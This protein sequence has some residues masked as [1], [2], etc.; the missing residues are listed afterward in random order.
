MN[1]FPSILKRTFIFS[2]FCFCGLIAQ[3]YKLK[4]SQISLT[5]E[6][7]SSPD[8]NLKGTVN[9]GSYS[10]GT[11]DSIRLKGGIIS[12]A[13]GLYSAPPTLKTFF[14]D[15]IKSNNDPVVARAIATD[16]N[17][18]SSTSLYV[19]LGGSSTSIKLNMPAVNDSLFEVVIPDS[20]LSARNF[21]AYF[22]SIDSMDYTK[23]SSFETPSLTIGKNELSMDSPFSYYPEGMARD[24]WRMFSWP[25]RLNEKAVTTSNLEEDGY[26]F[27]YWDPQTGK[28]VKPDTLSTGVGYW[29]QHVFKNPLILKNADTTA[30]ALPLKDYVIRLQKGWNMIGS[31]FSFR[32]KLEYDEEK[33]SGLYQ[34]GKEE[35]D[36]WDGPVTTFEPWAGYAIFNKTDQEDSIIVKPFSDTLKLKRIVTN[37]WEIALKATGKH[38]F[39]YTGRVGRKEDAI[40]QKD[41]YDS[42]VLPALNNFISISMDVDG[43]GIFSNSGDFRSLDQFNGT[44]DIRLSGKG[45][46]GPV[47]FSGNIL[48]MIPDGMSVAILDVQS[49]TVYNQF[50]LTGLTIQE[51]INSAYDLKLIIGDESYVQSTVQ[52]VLTNIPEEFSL[53]QNY[54]NPFNPTTKIDFALARTGNV[55]ILIYNLMGQQVKTLV[56]ESLDYGYHIITWNGLDDFGRQVPSGV[57]FSELRAKGFRQSKKMLLLK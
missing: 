2:W 30:S 38:Y 23:E 9:S 50:L 48:T 42:P 4:T 3:E 17:G 53:G 47:Y 35:G 39:Y 16:M 57:Y 24:K 31:P 43:D 7:M 28:K 27:Y 11:S 19:Q 37:D 52:E 49:R 46:P 13:V 54:P 26:V 29:F 41:R 10:T 22:E 36:G 55:N 8:L 40:D 33:I 5:S 56:S 12:A 15:T 32:T 45:E 51:K 21:R 1:N 44:W 14:P 34:F 6:V 20:L 25:G 18:I